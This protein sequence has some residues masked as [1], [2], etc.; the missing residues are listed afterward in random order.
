MRILMITDFYWPFVG[1]VEQHVRHLSRALAV[2]GH[3]VAVATLGN[4]SL[5]SVAY[6]GPVRVYRIQTSMQR[7]PGI[8]TTTERPWAPPF[9]DPEATLRLAQIIRREQPQ[10]L[11]G[12]DWLARSALPL[13]SMSGAK[14]VLSLHYYTLSCA[15]KNLMFQDVPCSGPEFTKCLGCA[16]AHY[17]LG[18]GI[19][20][21]FA[22]WIVSRLERANVDCFL[23]V[24]MATAMGNGL[25]DP[26]HFQIIP[27]FVSEGTNETND[28]KSYLAQL[29]EEPFLL[30]V[31]DLRRQKG[32]HVLLSAY[33]SL[34]GAPPLVLIG[35]VWNDTPKVFPANVTVLKNWPNE[36]VLVA[37][38]RSLMGIVP[39]IWPEPFGIVIIEAMISG[40][41]VIASS[42]GGIPDLVRHGSSGLLV[43]PG[44]PLALAYAI[45]CLLANPELREKMSRNARHQ[46]AAYRIAVVVPRVEHIYERLL[47]ASSEIAS[48]EA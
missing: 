22:N 8:F 10:I 9:P 20:I 11:H 23:P 16:A 47:Q 7:A 3:E 46:A 44:D 43:P 37:W 26:D 31:G 2:R 28:I 12:H 6:D 27:N 17:G 42:I 30:F 19:P 35:K 24:S 1:G 41:P 15:K 14:F 36:A 38:K 34:P 4:A 48:A 5:E 33:S 39:S 25:S 29:P 21:T 18:K 13:K 40:R 32:L 45:R